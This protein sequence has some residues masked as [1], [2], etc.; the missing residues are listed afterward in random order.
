MSIMASSYDN[1]DVEAGIR[2]DIDDFEGRLTM[3]V[4]NQPI[5]FVHPIPRVIDLFHEFCALTRQRTNNIQELR[6]FCFFFHLQ[7]SDT[8][9]GARKGATL[10]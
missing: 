4:A 2:K 1:N 10:K 7:H 6:D 5:A 8:V 9:G 3:V